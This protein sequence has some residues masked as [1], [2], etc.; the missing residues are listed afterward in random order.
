MIP[1][2]LNQVLA[3]R[4]ND[5]DFTTESA[6]FNDDGMY[7]YDSMKEDYG[8]QDLQPSPHSTPVP[9]NIGKSL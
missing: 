3:P 1:V 4:E 2:G 5:R 9:D 6:F 7:D 8:L